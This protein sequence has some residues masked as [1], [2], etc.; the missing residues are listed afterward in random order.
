MPV[1]SPHPL[2]VTLSLSFVAA[3]PFSHAAEKEVTLFN[4]WF[5]QQ[6]PESQPWDIGAELRGRFE[7]KDDAGVS[8]ATDFVPG[9]AESREAFYF[10]EKI[11]IGYK[12]DWIG[13]FI[14]GR[15]ASGHED[16]K[17]DDTFDL[18]QAYLTI[19][20]AREF[21]LTAQ[22][23]RQ[24][25]SYG[26]QRFIGKSDWSN[27]GRSFD[28]IKLRLENSFGWVD[29]FTSRVV[30]VDDGNFNVSNDYDYFSGLYAGS[31]Q[32][33]PWQDTQVYFLARNYGS[34][35]PNAIGPGNPGSPSTQRDIYTLG[36]LWKSNPDAFGCWDYSA[37]AAYQFGSVYNAAQDDRLDQQSYAIFLDGGYTWKDAWSTPRLGLGYEHGSGDGNAT[38]GK[39]ETFENLFGTQ[40]RP[41][42]LMDLVGAR[43]MHI[44][45][46]TFAMKPVKGLTLAADYLTFILA[47]TDDLFYPES[48]SGRSGNGYGI[49][50]GYGSYVGSEID[51]YANYTVTKWANFQVGYG[52]FFTGDYIEDSVGNSAQ[53]ADWCYTQLTLTF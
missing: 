38:D 13:G 43:N 51:L 2:L 6:Y 29:A 18:H 47:D 44:P 26:D 19:G 11:H 34:Q 5:H 48:G 9:L 36:T 53:D 49:N 21:P 3:C 46:I 22:I 35:G 32:L 20:N 27:T 24:E 42:G 30:L 25:L 37:E 12:T 52:H 23:G 16:L 8:A 40:H 14:E 39:V 50:P 4:E 45:K 31:K 28:A 15:D 10:R 41:Y 1:P 33:M 17:A 7:L